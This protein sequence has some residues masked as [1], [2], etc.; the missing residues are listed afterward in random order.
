MPAADRAGRRPGGGGSANRNRNR[1]RNRRLVGPGRQPQWP[2]GRS[3]GGIRS[4]G[5]SG[6]SPGR[7]QVR[8]GGRGPPAGAAAVVRRQPFTWRRGCRA[9]LVGNRPPS[10]SGSARS[11]GQ[12]RGTGGRDG[13]APAVDVPVAAAVDRSTEGNEEAGAVRANRRR[14]VHLCL[15]PGWSPGWWSA[16]SWWR[17]VC[18]SGRRGGVRGGRRRRVAG[19]CGSVAAGAVLRSLGARPERR[20]GASPAAQPGGRALRHHGPSPADHLRGRQP[21]A[22]RHG[23]RAGPG[24]A[25]RWW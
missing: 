25:P 8:G 11:A 3:G 7:R 12:R 1:N 22:Q 21:G 13:P 4:G 19:G 20:G 2:A 23:R 15:V 5:S 9:R 18:P 16:W 17:S 6:G 24:D 10:R 14:A